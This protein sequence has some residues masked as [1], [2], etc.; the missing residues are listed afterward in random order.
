MKNLPYTLAR[1][2]QAIF[3][4]QAREVLLHLSLEDPRSPG[5]THWIPVTARAAAPLLLPLFQEGVLRTEERISGSRSR[6]IHR[7]FP[8]GLSYW[9][10]VL[11]ARRKSS[12][13][14]LSFDLFNPRIQEAVEALTLTFCEETLATAAGELEESL[15]K[16]WELLREGLE[17]GEAYTWIAREVRRIFADPVRAYRIAATEGSRAL[18]AGQLLAAKESGVVR[19][20]RWLASSD[21]CPRCLAIDGKEVP[22]G[23]PFLVEGSGPYAVVKHPPL[24]PNC[25]CTVTEVLR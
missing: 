23:K 2:L 22:L 9:L 6:V 14:Q 18:H 19:G 10:R 8:F 24:H 5:L 25:F 17:R 4:S 13:L 16:L 12:A 21:A 20:L 3:T 15:Q 1:T 7:G 11:K